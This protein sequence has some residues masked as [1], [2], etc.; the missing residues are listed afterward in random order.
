M[1]PHDSSEFA[2]AAASLEE[3][4][5]REDPYA[6]S[7]EVDEMTV[8]SA[9]GHVIDPELG[10]DIVTLGLVYEIAIQGGRVQVTHTLTTP[11]CPMEEVIGNGIRTAVGAIPGV[12]S[13]TNHVVWEPRWH[14]GMIQEVAW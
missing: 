14:P 13:V 9:L 1:L 2:R 11:G 4:V 10:L 6:E 12:T 7:D 3:G 5:A 8:W